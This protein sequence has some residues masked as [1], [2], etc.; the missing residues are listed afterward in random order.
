MKRI[1]SCVL[2][3]LCCAGGLW[4]EPWGVM[5]DYDLPRT[6]P[7]MSRMAGLEQPVSSAPGERYLLKPVLEGRSIKVLLERGEE[8]EETLAVYR[9]KIQEA[10]SRWFLNAARVIRQAGREREFADI[11]PV[12]DKGIPVEFVPFGEDITVEFVDRQ[13]IF[14]LCGVQT[15]ACYR[16]EGPKIYVPKNP[17]GSR[18]VLNPFGVSSGKIFFRELLH[19]IGHSLGFSDQYAQARLNTHPIYHGDKTDATIM[20]RAVNLTCDDADGMVN[21]IDITRGKRRGGRVGWRSLCR[22]SKTYYIGGTALGNG[23]YMMW[24][25]DNGNAWMLREYRE[26]LLQERELAMAWG[27]G[28]SLFEPFAEQVL[29]RDAIG[30]PVLTQGPHGEKVYYSYLYG[31]MLRFVTAGD[32]I[33]LLERRER[34]LPHEKSFDKRIIAFTHNGKSVLLEADRRPAYGYLSYKEDGDANALTV[35]LTFK[36]GKVERG[37]GNGGKSSVARG[38]KFG[39]VTAA[40]GDTS[41]QA[42][43]KKQVVQKEREELEQKLTEWYLGL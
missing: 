4:A 30:R 5:G 43:V 32:K 23:P 15:A 11:L 22:N 19:E 3:C 13:E 2:S 8:E 16:F 14:R 38:M 34:N 1:V 24:P 37:S 35:N 6:G 33:L 41:M 28:I 10:Y 12:L 20:N 42:Q 7:G 25:K 26:G 29:E 31:R 40:L 9:E 39:M 18:S 36:K 21:L 17:R 27:K